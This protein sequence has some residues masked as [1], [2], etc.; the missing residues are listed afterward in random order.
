[1]TNDLVNAG[2][3]TFRK[4]SVVQ[5]CGNVTVVGSVGMHQQIDFSRGN[6]GLNLG[7]DMI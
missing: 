4:S 5:G 7:T 1:V 3:A 6:A 2:A